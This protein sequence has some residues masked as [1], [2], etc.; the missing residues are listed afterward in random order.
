MLKEISKEGSV[1][2]QNSDNLFVKVFCK[3][4]QSQYGATMFVHQYCS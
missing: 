3:N 2:S 4:S 1:F